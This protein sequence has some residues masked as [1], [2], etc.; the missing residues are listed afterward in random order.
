MV[1]LGE[2][3]E[4]FERFMMPLAGSATHASAMQVLHRVFSINKMALKIG[5]MHIIKSKRFV[6][7][8]QQSSNLHKFWH[9]DLKKS[10]IKED[11]HEQM[12]RVIRQT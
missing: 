12:S 7:C 2:D 4:R 11:I 9:R 5:Y 1:E 3:E 10:T 6:T 8:Y